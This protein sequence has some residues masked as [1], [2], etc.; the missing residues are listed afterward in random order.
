[1][2]NVTNKPILLS[3]FTPSVVMPSV[4]MLKVVA[5]FGGRSTVTKIKIYFN[6]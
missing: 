6:F 3:V 5:S 2:L 4:V 1:M